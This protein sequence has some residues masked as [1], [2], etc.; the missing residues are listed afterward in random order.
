MGK[1]G[2]ISSL[3][4]EYSKNSGTLEAALAEKGY[5]RFPG[6]GVRLV[7]FK[8][9]NGE[10]RTGLNPK[11]AYLNRLPE[12]SRK[13]EVARI[14]KRKK[15]LEELTGLDL[16]PRADYY[17]K[18]FD[19][20]VAIKASAYKLKEGDN[21]FNLSDPFAAITYEWLKVHPMIASS[22]QAYERG[23][24][25]ASTQFYVNDEEIEEELKYRK[26]TLIN[27]AIRELEDMSLEKRKKVA[28]LVGLPVGDNTKERTVYNLL[29][30]F[31][32]QYE[33]TTGEFKGANP[34]EL[35]NKIAQYD[36][37]LLS[38]KDLIGQALK[39]S[40]YRST[41]GGRITEGGVEIAKNKEDL[42]DFLMD[43]KNQD[44]LLALQEKLKMKKAVAF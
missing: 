3:K 30:S 34:L 40:V 5:S 2:K 27:R 39:H 11:A 23:E 14:T 41:K 20:N 28:R 29:D 32:K 38:V 36:D 17:S 19:E 8:E 6:T 44:D 31:I 4:K 43:E 10:Y 24:Y 18:I 42:E 9:P 35:F 7:P 16:G 12:E 37:T 15:E 33:I 22:Y 21:I 13:H 26:K 1:T 25:P